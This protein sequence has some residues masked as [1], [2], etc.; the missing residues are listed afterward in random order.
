[1]KRIATLV[2]IVLGALAVSAGGSASPSAT[3]LIGTDGPGFVIT[4]KNA[5]GVRVTRLRHG[6]YTIV[7]RDRSSIHNFH[8]RGP[9]AVNKKTTVGFVG[10]RTWTVRLVAGTYRYICD[11]HAASMRG[12]FRVT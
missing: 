1:M 11:P 10:T 3:K 7:V 12:S 4:L 8:L 5:R 2:V 9:G 6:T